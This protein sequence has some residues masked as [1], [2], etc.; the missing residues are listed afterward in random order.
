VPRKVFHYRRGVRQGDPLSPLLFVL[1]ANLLQSIVNKAWMEGLLQLP[2]HVGY[3]QDFPIV[4]YVDGTLLIMETCP[5][6]LKSLLN[7]FASATGLKV[8]YAKSSMVSINTTPEKLE[9]LAAIFQCQ[10]GSL[11][12]TYLRLLLCLNQSSVQYCWPLVQR[13]EVRLTPSG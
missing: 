2:I 7:T 4:Q 5:R 11:P 10:A 9:H 13:I 1:A 8:N 6:Q 12:F 3:T